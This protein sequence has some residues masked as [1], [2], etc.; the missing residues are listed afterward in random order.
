MIVSIFVGIMKNLSSEIIENVIF[1]K[2]PPLIG[3]FITTFQNQLIYQRFV[4][5]RYL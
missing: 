5:F 1:K 4:F 2:K 3:Q